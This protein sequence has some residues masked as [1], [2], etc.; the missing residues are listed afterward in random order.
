MSDLPV[1][2]GHQVLQHVADLVRALREMKRVTAPGGV[3]A[4]RDSDYG[5]FTWHPAMELL[6]RA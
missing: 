1:V 3:I 4:V 2:H 6:A 5:M